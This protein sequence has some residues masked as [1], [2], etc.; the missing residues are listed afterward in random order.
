MSLNI[1]PIIVHFPI[2]FLFVYSFVK[3]LP[4]HKW[5]PNVA[6]LDIQKILVTVGVLG[7]FVASST[8]EIASELVQVN[9]DLIEAHELFAGITTWLYVILLISE[10]LPWINLKFIEKLQQYKIY[11]LSLI[12]EKFISNK[13]LG[14]LLAFC[15]LVAVVCTGMLGGVIVYGPTL[16]PLAPILLNILGINL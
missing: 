16:D 6:W 3:I 12:L 13:T 11:N 10:F 1:H 8:G 14:I 2:A 15:A 7:A 4:L 9:H 5:L